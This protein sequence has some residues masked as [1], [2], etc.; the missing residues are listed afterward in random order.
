MG[1]THFTDPSGL[2]VPGVYST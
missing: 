2:R 1:N